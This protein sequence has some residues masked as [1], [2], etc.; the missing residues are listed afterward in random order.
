MGKRKNT[1]ET[2]NDGIHFHVWSF[3]LTLV[4]LASLFGGGGVFLQ[5]SISSAEYYEKEMQQF[6][7]MQEMKEMYEQRIHD[8]EQEIY[9][10][11]IANTNEQKNHK[12]EKRVDK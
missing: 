4:T 5:K 9:E 1:K 3:V 8:L 7:E 6:V 11:R 2:Q 10:L 12:D